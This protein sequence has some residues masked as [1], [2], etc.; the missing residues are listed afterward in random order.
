MFK[1]FTPKE[2]ISSSTALKSSI[3]RQHRQKLLA[4]YP[5]LSTAALPL[6]K[7]EDADEDLDSDEEPQPVQQR[8]KGAG[9]DKREKKEDKRGGGKGGKKG[10]QQEE[11]VEDQ[12]E[13]QQ[14]A[15]ED[16]VL[17]VLDTIWPKKEGLT[18]VKCK[19]ALTILALHGEPLF[20]QHFE[21]PYYPTLKILHK[22]PALLPRVGVDRGAIKFVLAGANIMCPGLTSP[23]AY[24]PPTSANI[25][26]G[27]PVAVYAYGKEEAL[28]IGLTAMSTDDIR[29]INKNCGVET[30]TYL[31][32]DLWRLEKI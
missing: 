2:D 19:D 12:S 15:G 31:G 14:G 27:T 11:V 22:Y 21:G 32:D 16:E 3:Q 23:T 28:A 4:Q 18:L 30:V 13:E 26:S 29:N 25:P 10:R 5:F 17:T 20:F 7:N 8:K 9:K 6:P 24:L 1:K